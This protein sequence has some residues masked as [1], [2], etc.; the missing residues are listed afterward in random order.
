MIQNKSKLP[1]AVRRDYFNV[2]LIVVMLRIIMLSVVMLNVVTVKI[3]APNWGQSRISCRKFS[4]PFWKARTFYKYIQYLA[5][6]RK[7]LA[8]KNR[9]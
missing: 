7:D 5:V 3:V 1:Y 2:M 6:S 9:E 8:Y 4:L